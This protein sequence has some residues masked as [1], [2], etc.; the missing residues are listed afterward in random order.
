MN[1]Y[2]KKYF[3]FSI[4]LFYN[5]IKTHNIEILFLNLNTSDNHSLEF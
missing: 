3:T 1:L 4:E 5:L 2:I